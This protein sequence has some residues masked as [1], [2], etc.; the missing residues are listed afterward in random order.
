MKSFLLGLGLGASLA[1]LLD[2]QLGR[3]RRALTRDRVAATARRGA[4]QLGRVRRKATS[5]VA[6]M[7]ERISHLSFTDSEPANDAD[8]KARVETELFRD[9][10]IPKGQININVENRVVVLRGEL[11]RPE[12]INRIES[13]VESIPGVA[14][15][16]NLLHLRNTPARHAS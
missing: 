7:E 12:E 15:V 14:D 3:R 16:E 9:P 5:D 8:L 1:Y 6:G 4:R 13:K 2:P 10:D 11:N